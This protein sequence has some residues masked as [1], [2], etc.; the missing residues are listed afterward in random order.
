[1]SQQRFRLQ[2]VSSHLLE[3]TQHLMLRHSG[4]HPVSH[5]YPRDCQSYWG[6]ALLGAPVQPAVPT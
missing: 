3:K 1:M 4:H 6:P 2:S 5:P